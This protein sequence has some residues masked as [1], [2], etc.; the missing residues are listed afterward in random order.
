MER[1][2]AIWDAIPR[3]VKYL[4]LTLLLHAVSVKFPQLPLPN[5]DVLDLLTGGGL[6]GGHVLT[7]ISANLGVLR[8]PKLAV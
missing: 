1:L 6:L 4:A 7:D 8:D 3:K 2:K 5:P